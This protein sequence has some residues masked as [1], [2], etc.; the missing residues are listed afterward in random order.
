MVN[1]GD[2]HCIRIQVQIIFR[3]LRTEED[4]NYTGWVIVSVQN[5]TANLVPCFCKFLVFVKG[6]QQ[7]I[8]IQY[9][10]LIPSL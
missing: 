4:Q 2:I 7:F 3:H 10:R 5:L 6:N 9:T 8:I 1:M